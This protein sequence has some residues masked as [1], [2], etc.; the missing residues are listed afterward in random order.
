MR[1]EIKKPGSSQYV[2]LTSRSVTADGATTYRYKMPARGTYYFRVRFLGTTA[3][4]AVASASRKVI[5][6]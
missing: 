2:L 3:F 1:F 4:K 6:K 5:C